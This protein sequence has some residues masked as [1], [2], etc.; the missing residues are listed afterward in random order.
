MYYYSRGAY[1]AINTANLTNISTPDMFEGTAE[2]IVRCQTYEGGFAGEPGLEAHGGYSFCGL[3]ALI[4][5][6]KENLCDIRNLLV[7]NYS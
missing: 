3:A 5:L 2:W 7:S 1:C 6:S 4:L